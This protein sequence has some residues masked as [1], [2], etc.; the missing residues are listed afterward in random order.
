MTVTRYLGIDGAG[1]RFTPLGDEAELVLRDDA[2]VEDTWF[3]DS[4]EAYE[5]A[6]ALMEFAMGKDKERE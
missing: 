5:L 4:D 1:W 2:G 6:T 3:F